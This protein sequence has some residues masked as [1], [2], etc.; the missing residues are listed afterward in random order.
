M[1]TLTPEHEAQLT[2]HAD[3]WIA[4]ALSTDPIDPVRVKAIM[5]G[6][7]EAVSLAKPIVAIVPSPIA[8]R[9]A[10]GFAAAIW[11]IR[12]HAKPKPPRAFNTAHV[13]MRAVYDATCEAVGVVPNHSAALTVCGEEDDTQWHTGIGDM[14]AVADALCTGYANELMVC[15]NDTYRMWDSGNQW[16]G[17]AAYMSFFRYV[18]KLDIDYSKWDWY[19]QAAQHSGPRVTHEKFCIVSDRPSKIALEAGFTPHAIGEPYI[20]WRDGTGCWLVHNVRLPARFARNPG[21]VTKCDIDAAES[22]DVRGALLGLY[23]IG[24]YFEGAPPSDSGEIGALWRKVWKDGTAM[25]VLRI[26]DDWIKVAD[27][28]A[29]L[30][31]AVKSMMAAR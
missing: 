1:Y 13:A 14:R 29:T 16:S 4:S 2:P 27:E 9:Y 19:E 10:G 8:L 15:S 17:W 3:K 12:K 18:A 28:C 20:Q 23:G 31:D 5:L 30:E 26:G 11:H 24:R 25:A 6:L 7:Y 21:T 22:A